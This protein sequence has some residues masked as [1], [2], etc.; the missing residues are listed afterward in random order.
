MFQISTHAK[1]KYFHVR[2]QYVFI[3]FRIFININI[4]H[5]QAYTHLG[6]EKIDIPD[7]PDMNM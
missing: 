7:R 2:L 5:R 1:R 4:T 6:S 3:S